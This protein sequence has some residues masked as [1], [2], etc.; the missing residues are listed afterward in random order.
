MARVVFIPLRP[1]AFLVHGNL[2]PTAPYHDLAV[3]VALSSYSRGM[4]VAVWHVCEVFLGVLAATATY[5]AGRGSC[6]RL[7]FF[8]RFPTSK[9]AS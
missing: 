4:F 9:V 1:L 8:H 5:K 2:L 7:V 3:W 6:I